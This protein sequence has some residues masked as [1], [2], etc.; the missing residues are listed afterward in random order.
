[1]QLIIKETE[2]MLNR[3]KDYYENDKERLRELARNKYRN[4]SEEE[5][6]KKREYGKNRYQNMSEEKKQELKYIKNKDIEKQKTL[7]I[8]NKI[9]YL[10]LNP[11]I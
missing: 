7:E 1:M 5:K 3:A 11:Y 4:L 6:E 10:L 8:I 9:V 2:I